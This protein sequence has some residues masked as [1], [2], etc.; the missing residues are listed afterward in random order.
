MSCTIWP[1]DFVFYYLSY[2]CGF[3]CC[4]R[5]GSWHRGIFFNSQPGL[6]MVNFRVMFVISVGIS[7]T[8]KVLPKPILGLIK[9]NITPKPQEW[10]YTD[11]TLSQLWDYTDPI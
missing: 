2:A 1:S 7:Q 4:V 11:P 3:L 10:D 5:I 9:P 8:G 6:K